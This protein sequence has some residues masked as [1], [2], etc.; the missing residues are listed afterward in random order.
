VRTF[1]LTDLVGSTAL[2]DEEPGEMAAALEKHDSLVESVIAAARGSLVQSKGKAIPPFLSSTMPW[3]P[4]SRPARLS[5]RWA[6]LR[7]QQDAR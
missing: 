7:G 1:L 4:W 6:E 3:Q 2:W 5:R